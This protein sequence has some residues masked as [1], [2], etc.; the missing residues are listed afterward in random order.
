MNSSMKLIQK[1]EENVSGC[2]A[3]GWSSR[4][5]AATGCIKMLFERPIILK[6]S[7]TETN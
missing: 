2:D 7:C 5:C 3:R 1:V 4:Y 6:R